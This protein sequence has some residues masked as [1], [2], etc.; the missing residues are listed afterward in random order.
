MTKMTMPV[1]MLTTKT[2]LLTTIAISTLHSSKK[3]CSESS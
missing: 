2:I 3:N 1:T